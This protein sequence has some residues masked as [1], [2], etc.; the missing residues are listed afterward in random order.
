MFKQLIRSLSLLLPP[1][2]QNSELIPREGMEIGPLW[3]ARANFREAADHFLEAI[4]ALPLKNTW[5]PG[6]VLPS[7][8]Q[9]RVGWLAVPCRMQYFEGVL[10]LVRRGVFVRGARGVCAAMAWV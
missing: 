4:R 10:V 5:S 9:S 1:P 3:L 8:V 6:L 7:K 2:P